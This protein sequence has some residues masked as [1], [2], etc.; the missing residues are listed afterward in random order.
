[1]SFK[2]DPGRP[3]E[4]KSESFEELKDE[5]EAWAGEGGKGWGG[6]RV[7]FEASSSTL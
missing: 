6:R 2:E 3:M 4:E 1:M 5:R 7:S